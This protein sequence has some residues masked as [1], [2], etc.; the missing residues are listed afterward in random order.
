MEYGFFRKIFHVPSAWR[1]DADIGQLVDHRYVKS[2]TE[3][4]FKIIYGVLKRKNYHSENSEMLHDYLNFM[5]RDFLDLNRCV[6]MVHEDFSRF[7]SI[8]SMLEGKTPD[9]FIHTIDSVRDALPFEFDA[10]KPTIM[11]VKTGDSANP[12]GKFSLIA[13]TII[14]TPNTLQKL[15]PFMPSED[16]KY[17]HD[18][19]Q[20]FRIEYTYWR[21]CIQ[22][23]RILLNDIPQ[24]DLRTLD[25]HDR[26]EFLRRK[27]AFQLSLSAY[28]AGV[29]GREGL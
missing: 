2:D 20:L 25:I 19:F 29:L 24:I 21:A 18:N 5:I 28:A 14:V 9:F 11:D 23:G 10:R 27:T 13:N 22:F 26:E 6:F 4:A 7:P 3:E 17:I 15:S 16:I 8:S 12:Y 1:D